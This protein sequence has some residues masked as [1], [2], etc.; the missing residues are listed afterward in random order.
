MNWVDIKEFVILLVGFVLGL[1]GSLWHHYIETKKMK[2][3]FAI[4]LRVII[5]TEASPTVS[6]VDAVVKSIRE[7]IL[8]KDPELVRCQFFPTSYNYI[9]EKIALLNSEIVYAYIEYEQGLNAAERNRS[10]Y[11]EKLGGENMTEIKKSK[12]IYLVG[13]DTYIKRSKK[14]LD[15]IEKFYNFSDNKKIPSYQETFNF[16]ELSK[17]MNKDIPDGEKFEIKFE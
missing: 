3:N 16:Y 12:F 10:L 13:L 4:L 15:T 5:L 1:L 6:V 2:E 17:V 7:K 8:I 11:I 14:L 9:N